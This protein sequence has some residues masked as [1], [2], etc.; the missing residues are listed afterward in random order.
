MFS[1]K[2]CLESVKVSGSHAMHGMW[3]ALGTSLAVNLLLLGIIVN[4]W[5]RR[6]KET[7]NHSSFSSCRC[8]YQ[9]M[10]DDVEIQPTK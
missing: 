10:V 7:R 3:G 8:V 9:S 4:C 2:E 6:T 5:R 1:H